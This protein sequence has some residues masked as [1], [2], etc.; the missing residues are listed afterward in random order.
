MSSLA[1]TGAAGFVGRHLVHAMH[2]TGQSVRAISRSLPIERRK[3]VDYRLN[4][5]LSSADEWRELFRDV[6]CVV[7]LAARAHIVGKPDRHAAEEFKRVNTEGTATLARAAAQCRVRR[8]VLVSTAKVHGEL[9]RP[10]RPFTAH[11]APAPA[12]PYAISKWEA[13]KAARDIGQA[14]G[15][16]VVVVRPP[17]VYG[18]GVRA[19]FQSMMDWLLRGIPLPFGSIDNRRSLVGVG[20]LV[21]F[22]VRCTEVPDAASRTF[23]VSDGEDLSTRELLRRLARQLAVPARLIPVPPPVLRMAAWA[24]RRSD[25]YIKLCGNLQLDIRAGCDTLKWQPPVS[26]DE[27]LRQTAFAYRRRRA[28]A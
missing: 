23:L 10:G 16:D 3:G 13:E 25:V 22:I 18:P 9:S 5:G 26:V 17:L 4:L 12:D 6:D 27:G 1:V 7:H 28:H 14:S 11:D 24:V 15:M 8:F 20:N 2:G 21:D 19:N